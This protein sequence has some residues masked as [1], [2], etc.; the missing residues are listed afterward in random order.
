MFSPKRKRERAKQKPPMNL[1]LQDRVVLEKEKEFWYYMKLFVFFILLP[2][3]S[4]AVVKWYVPRPLPPLMT[5]EMFSNCQFV[6]FDSSLHS[7]YPEFET[8]SARLLFF[9]KLFFSVSPS[10]LNDPNLIKLVEVYNYPSSDLSLREKYLYI[11][12]TFGL[13]GSVDLS[14]INSLLN[15]IPSKIREFN[16]SF[17]FS[18]LNTVTLQNFRSFHPFI[19]VK[20]LF[21]FAKPTFT[22][23]K[24]LSYLFL[25]SNHLS[26]SSHDLYYSDPTIRVDIYLVRLFFFLASLFLT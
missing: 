20:D 12:Q 11:S 8:H 19:K 14:L 26:S 13:K 24:P 4:Y 23:M 22:G 18:F 7:S 10:V 17:P 21:Y 9:K 6:L 15:L 25:L 16:D 2:L 3:L 5:P 1:N